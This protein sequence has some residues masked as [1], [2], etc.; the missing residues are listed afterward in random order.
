MK[1]TRKNCPEKFLQQKMRDVIYCDDTTILD[2][3]LHCLLVPI[4]HLLG[5]DVGEMIGSTKSSSE[6]YTYCMKGHQLFVEPS[7][8]FRILAL[9]I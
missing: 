9:D 2:V 1:E 3:D 8:K 6:I 4:G 5:L 7:R